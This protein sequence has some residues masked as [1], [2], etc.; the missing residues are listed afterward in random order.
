MPVWSCSWTITSR[1]GLQVADPVVK[2]LPLPAAADPTG[3]L[4]VL[5]H[6]YVLG[7]GG[8]EGVV[9]HHQDRGLALLIY[10]FEAG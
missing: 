7:V 2:F 5:Q 8:A 4:A 3:D 6:V 1:G 9:G 10:R